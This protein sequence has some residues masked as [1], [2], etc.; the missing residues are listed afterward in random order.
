MLG[1]RVRCHRKGL[2]LVLK[3]AVNSKVW[4]LGLGLG[5]AIA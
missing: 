2:R 5:L 4:W 1:A 3:F